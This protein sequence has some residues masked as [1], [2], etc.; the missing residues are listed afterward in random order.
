MI[1]QAKTTTTALLLPFRTQKAVHEVSTLLKWLCSRSVNI[2]RSEERSASK[3]G[4]GAVG[5]GSAPKFP[6]TFALPGR[7]TTS[8][9]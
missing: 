5:E 1:V 8:D 3:S 2:C 7:I 9:E 6:T 4:G